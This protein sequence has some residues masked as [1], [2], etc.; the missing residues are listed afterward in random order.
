M[1]PGRRF[2]PLT[3]TFVRHLNYTWGHFLE[4]AG[5]VFTEAFAGNWIASLVLIGCSVPFLWRGRT[6]L[7]FLLASTTLTV[8]MAVVYGQVWHFGTVFLAW[9]LA[10]WLAALRTRPGWLASAAL[11]AVLAIHGFWAM[12]SV[13][14]ELRSAYSGGISTARYF[15]EHRLPEAGLYGVGYACVA[16]QPYFRQNI[17]LNFQHSFWY[18][19]EQN[20]M[21]QDYDNLAESRPPWVL[22]GY[23]TDQENYL[24]NNQVRRS[25][26]RKIK[27]FEGNIIWKGEPFEPES[28]DLYQRQ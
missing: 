18:W 14:Q 5:Q 2:Q 19:S 13:Y 4:K 17:F 8:L 3:W 11:V 27:H 15:A 12:T 20:H 9:I 22:V 7:L 28:F 1:Q 10:L 23:K 25:G 16:V 24:W 21:I 6:F 26:Y